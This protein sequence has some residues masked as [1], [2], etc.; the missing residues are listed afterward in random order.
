MQTNL[1][2]E[3]VFDL[4]ALF[5]T[6]L[7]NPAPVTDIT[8]AISDAAV[9]TLTVDAADPSKVL[10]SAVAPGT[11]VITVEAKD[12]SDTSKTVDGAYNVVVEQAGAVLV[13]FVAS[14][15]RLKA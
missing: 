7:N 13:V 1:T 4:Q 10:V 9:A 6:A 15:P 14:V 5:T 11:A 2:N 8:W 3:Q 12:A